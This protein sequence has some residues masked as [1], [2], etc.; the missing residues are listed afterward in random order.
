MGLLGSLLKTTIHVATTPLEVVKDVA[1][2]GGVL[3]DQDEPY[4]VQRI[5]KLARDIQEVEDEVDDL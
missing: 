5:K 3:T 4:A 1:T 2:L